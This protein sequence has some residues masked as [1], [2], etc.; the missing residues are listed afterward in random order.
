MFTTI[1]ISLILVLLAFGYFIF[2]SIKLRL[3]FDDTIRFMDLS[4][5]V[6]RSRLRLNGESEQI[7]MVALK[8]KGVDLCGILITDMSP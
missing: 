7:Y 8:V 5:S 1:H 4:Y 6:F 3:K 2:S